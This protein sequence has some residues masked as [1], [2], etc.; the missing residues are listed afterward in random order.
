MSSKTGSPSFTKQNKIMGGVYS[1]RGQ[2]AIAVGTCADL[3]KEDYIFPLHRDQG[4]FL[5]KG[6]DPKRLMAQMLGKEEGFS[7]GRDSALHAG[8]PEHGIIGSTSMLGS[9]LPVACGV[10]LKFKL[11]KEPFVAVSYFGEG[12]ASRGDVHEAMNFAG[13]HKLPVLFVCENNQFAYS[14]PLRLQMAIPNVADRAAAYGFEGAIC[15]GNDLAAVVETT[16]RALKRARAG[17]DRPSSSAR[18]TASPATASTIP[19]PTGPRTRSPSGPSATP[20][21]SGSN[22]SRSRGATWRSSASRSSR[23]P[24]AS[25][26]K[27]RL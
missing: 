21:L 3:K 24:A 7:R 6:A 14:T 23:R 18:P 4:T 2:E 5:V 15:N 10:A 19:P 12:A 17:E 27:R 9:A 13:V 16:Q 26:M 25:S 20:S 22:I 8:D 1:G 11:R